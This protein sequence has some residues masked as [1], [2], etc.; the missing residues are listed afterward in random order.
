MRRLDSPHEANSLAVIAEISANH[1]GSLERAKQLVRVAK[2]AG[3]TYVKLQHYRPDTITVRGKAPELK[4][5]GG[6]LW[7][8]RSLWELYTEAMTPWEWTSEIDAIAREVG[9]PWF[10]TP[11][12]ETAVD[13]LETFD[14]PIYKIASFEIVD[15]PLVRH[16]AQTG[17]PMI[18]ST[19]MA[20]VEEIDAAVDAAQGA[21]A[22]DI[23]LLRTNSAYP[24]SPE[25]MDLSAIPFMQERWGLPVGLSDHTLG[26]T[27]AVVATA[28]GACLFEKHLTIARSD[29][30]PDSAFSAE[31]DEI[32]DYV[33]SIREAGKLLGTVRFGPSTR[34]EASLKLRPSLRAIMD[35]AKGDL[36]SAA[37]VASVRPAGGLPP[38]MIES[39]KGN[40]APSDIPMGTP[41]T[42]DLL[43]DSSS[44]FLDI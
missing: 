30:G 31:P 3:V 44:L 25:E 13:F 29:G 38:D 9:I 19:G 26:S 40:R 24:A 7:D 39:T 28:L 37:N 8:G 35:I 23:T 42:P 32:K 22:S 12:D 27:A 33:S 15:L 16:V 41:I 10:S 1:L 43:Q 4:V 21:G 2:Q 5:S 11:F 18:I 20:T 34:E 14:V 17:K 6:T 36:F